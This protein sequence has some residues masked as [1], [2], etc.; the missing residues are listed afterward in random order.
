VSVVHVVLPFVVFVSALIALPPVAAAT[1]TAADAL[2]TPAENKTTAATAK[3]IFPNVRKGNMFIARISSLS[4]S[5]GFAREPVAQAF[6][7][8]DELSPERTAYF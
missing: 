4:C 2:F 8:V 7:T 3:V 6:N 5:Y 1:V